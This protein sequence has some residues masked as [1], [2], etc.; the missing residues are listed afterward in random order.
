M[1]PPIPEKDFPGTGTI[2]RIKER[3][4]EEEMRLLA[5]VRF[6]DTFDAGL[7]PWSAAADV[8][9]LWRFMSWNPS[10]RLAQRFCHITQA[11]GRDVTV[12]D[13]FGL[14]LLVMKDDPL[15]R[16]ELVNRLISRNYP[17]DWIVRLRG[18]QDPNTEIDWELRAI[19]KADWE[20]ELQKE[21]DN[22]A[23]KQHNRS[24]Q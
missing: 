18:G 15:S 22:A 19:R 16:F 11:V 10:V 17:I 12:E 4:S 20:A 3:I 21:Q 2:G 7:L 8:L 5:L 24:A 1:D 9:D 23:D 14:T 6:P 13:R